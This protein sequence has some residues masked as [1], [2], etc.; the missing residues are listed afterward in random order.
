MVRHGC[1]SATVGRLERVGHGRDRR[2]QRRVL[3]CAVAVN[4]LRRLRS[5]S[6][7]RR[8]ASVSVALRVLDVGFRFFCT[9]TL[10]SVLRAYADIEDPKRSFAAQATTLSYPITEGDF[11]ML[12]IKYESG[13]EWPLFAN[14]ETLYFGLSIRF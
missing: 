4:R 6:R 13:R 7:R 3:L 10:Q 1:I 14:E 2:T 11:A 12:T 8:G 5:E 9:L